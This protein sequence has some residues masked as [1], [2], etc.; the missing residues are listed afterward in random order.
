MG[1]QY[2]LTQLLDGMSD[3]AKEL[4]VLIKKEFK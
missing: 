4:L 1:G 2:R 3:R